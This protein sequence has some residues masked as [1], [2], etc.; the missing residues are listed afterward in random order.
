[1]IPQEIIEACGG[2]ADRFKLIFD[3]HSPL[4][5]NITRPN[6]LVF[7]FNESEDSPV[8]LQLIDAD[9]GEV[10]DEVGYLYDD[11]RTMV[12]HMV[13]PPARVKFKQTDGQSRV[14]VWQ[15]LNRPP[16]WLPNG[17]RQGAIDCTRERAHLHERVR[18]CTTKQKP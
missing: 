6:T 10:F 18:K 5:D 3:S 15:V 14:R 9:S 11:I 8:W 12:L 16:R 4:P 13:D 17:K 1:M 7:Q 2:Q